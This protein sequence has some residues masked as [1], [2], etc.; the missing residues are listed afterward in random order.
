M[1]AMRRRERLLLKRR[2]RRCGRL[3]LCVGLLCAGLVIARRRAW[4]WT[5]ADDDDGGGDG[6]GAG[7][8]FG[9]ASSRRRGFAARDA[10]R[11]PARDA[12]EGEPTRAVDGA[13][14]TCGVGGSAFGE[15]GCA[16]ERAYPDLDVVSVAV[17]PSC[18]N[19]VAVAALNQYVG[20][21]RIVVVAPDETRC[22]TFRGM[23]TNVECHAEDAFIRGLTKDAV[24]WYLEDAYGDSLGRDGARARF[25][26]RELG[27]WYLQQL[28]KLGAATS[29]AI[30]HPPLSRKFLLWD[31]DMIPLRPLTLFKGEIPVR[32]IGGNVIKSYEAAYETLTGDRLKYAKDGTSYVTHQMVVDASIM[33][34]MLD[35]FARKADRTDELATTSDELP[36]WATAVLQSLNRKD[37]TLG[38]S[39]YATYA[40]YVVDNH[41]SEV[42]VESRKK[43]AR[44]S[45]GKLGIS[46][47]RWINHDGLCCPGPGVLGLMK[48]RRFDYV[49]HEIGHV[50]SCRYDSPEHEFSYGLP[51][52]VP[53]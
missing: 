28:I 49:G 11:A 7:R 35:A 26:G 22:E 15:R 24:S 30:A 23:A 43:W 48:S 34:E 51:I 37:L 44:A 25:V 39:E 18:V 46:F 16:N 40:S 12:P 21:R 3:A 36:R 53:D 33:E 47:Q 13:A 29:T 42:S 5:D 50:E 8:G 41:P 4:T 27:G 2:V 45:G 38:F 6:G 17:K 19:A 1:S 52:T 10:A 31:L 32:Q 9:R 20:P 14:S